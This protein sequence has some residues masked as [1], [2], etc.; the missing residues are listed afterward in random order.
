L[1]GDDIKR[2]EGSDTGKKRKSKKI[3]KKK[4]NTLPATPPP[5]ACT[6]SSV[7]IAPFQIAIIPSKILWPLTVPVRCIFLI[8]W[9]L[10]LSSGPGIRGPVVGTPGDFTEW[11]AVSR[12]REVLIERIPKKNVGYLVQW[13]SGLVPEDCMVV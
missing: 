5:T 10:Y 13:Y 1:S 8:V 3:K 12:H 11:K 7:I 9:Q 4:K 2:T 6:H